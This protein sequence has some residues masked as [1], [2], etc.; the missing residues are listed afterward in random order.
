MVGLAAQEGRS[1][2]EIKI[3]PPTAE[4]FWKHMGLPT[5]T[6]RLGNSGGIYAHKILPQ[7]FALSGGERVPF[8]VEFFT[9]EERCSG[10][11]KPFSRFS[12]FGE[13]LSDNQIQLPQRVYCFNPSDVGRLPPTTA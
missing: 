1:V 5:V 11:P 12:G 6:D 8:S 13:R 10:T 7:I 9:E 2:V 4:P 3:A